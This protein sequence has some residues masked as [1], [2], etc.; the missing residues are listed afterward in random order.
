MNDIVSKISDD[1]KIPIATLEI[2]IR[3][4]KTRCRKFSIPKK[5]GDTRQIIQPSVKV[6]PILLWLSL[7]ILDSLPVHSAA[8]AFRRG[9]SILDNTSKH[10]E[11]DY[12]VRL[13]L[14]DFFP[15]IRSKDLWRVM[16]DSRHLIPEWS[17]KEDALR[18][19]SNVCFDQNSQLPIGYSTSPAIANSV[20]YRID[21]TLANA[22]M[23]DSRFGAATITRYADDFVFSTNKR[24]ACKKFFELLH[25]VVEAASSP[26][27]QINESKTRYMSRAG[28]STIIT[29]LR[30]NNSGAVVVHG[31]YRDHVRLLLKLFDSG[32]LALDQVPQLAGHLAYI[33]H[34]DPALFTK[35]SFK[36]YKRIEEI[37]SLQPVE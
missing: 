5:N 17:I 13:D 25:E 15:S 22:V 35:L 7:N 14:K 8:T 3:L 12:S 16:L 9:K 30:V 19:I 31:D 27:L 21:T 10:K 23:D 36:H 37:R 18:L 1:L 20:M 33:E 11:A 29:G 32:K 24:G 34:V 6:K 26:S 2:A 4:A 28:G